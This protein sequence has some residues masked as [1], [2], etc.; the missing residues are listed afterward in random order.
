MGSRSCSCWSAH[1]ERQRLTSWWPVALMGV[2]ARLAEKWSKTKQRN[3]G[4]AVERHYEHPQFECYI[5]LSKACSNSARLWLRPEKSTEADALRAR[6][7]NRRENLA[8][9][10]LLCLPASASVEMSPSPKSPAGAPTGPEKEQRWNWPKSRP[11]QNV[12]L[13]ILDT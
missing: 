1:T 12:D 4:T 11:I 7:T 2:I 13:F 6:G 3:W 10:A 9:L 8:L 5:P